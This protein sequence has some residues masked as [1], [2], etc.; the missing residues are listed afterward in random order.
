M[1]DCPRAH[2]PPRLTGWS[3]APSSFFAAA[4]RTTPAWPLRTTSASASMTRTVSP[5][6]AWQ[7]GQTL[8]FQ[9]ATPGMMSSSG[10]NLISWFSGL[11]QLASVALVPV[12][13]VSLI[14][15]R[16]SIDGWRLEVTGQTID[17][18]FALVMT[19]HAETHRVLDAALGHRLLTD[20]AVTGRAVDLGADVR[21][22]VELDVVVVG[23]A[24][25]PLPRQ[26]DPHLVHFGDLLDA[27]PVGGDR[28]MTDHAGAQAG[29]PCDRALVDPLVTEL[30]GD[31][32]AD[33]DVVRELQGLR[34]FGEA[35]QEIVHRRAHR[36]AHGGV[37]ARGLPR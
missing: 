35:V 19:V 10:T 5:Q 18:R 13:A 2:R 37:D 4:I 6:P 1:A 20:V 7:S 22:V 33:V 25:H 29:N 21:S 15:E 16:R 36:R 12:M 27:R 11:P 3:E 26:V 32:L 14:K 28:R 23:E 9:V 34:R 17:R 30:A 8:G 24:V 31:F